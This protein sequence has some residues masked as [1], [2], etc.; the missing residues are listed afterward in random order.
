MAQIPP[1]TDLSTVPLAPNPNGNLPNFVNPP[2]QADTVL[3]VGLPLVIISTFV[4]AVR[5]ATNFRSA[6]KLGLDDCKWPRRGTLCV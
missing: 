5:L 3:G 1:G 2:S 6:R 4:V